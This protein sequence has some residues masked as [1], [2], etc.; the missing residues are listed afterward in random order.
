MLNYIRSLIKIQK[1]KHN[2]KITEDTYPKIKY[3]AK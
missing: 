1:I 3:T 2:I